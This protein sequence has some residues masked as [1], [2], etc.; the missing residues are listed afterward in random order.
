MNF[1]AYKS[2]L[3]KEYPQTYNFLQTNLWNPVFFPEPVPLSSK[4]YQQM[5]TV[6]QAL[7]QL[8]NTE[9]YQQ[10][11]LQKAPETA[12][13]Q[14]KM[15]SVLMAYDFHIDPKGVPKLIEVNTNASAFLLVNSFFPI[16]KSAL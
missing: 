1:L 6:V 13:K 9:E 14:Q 10:S 11:L 12:L 4:A 3:K 15:D 7:F 5:K 16:S 2:F 8:K